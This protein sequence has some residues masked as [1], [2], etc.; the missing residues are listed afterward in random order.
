[1]KTVAL[2][3]KKTLEALL[4]LDWASKPWVFVLILVYSLSRVWQLN[5]GFGLYGDAWRI[6]NTAFDISY[7][8]IYNPSRFP[9]YPLPEFIDS[10]FIRWGWVA[11]NGLAAVLNLVAVFAFASI[12]KDLGVRNK[13]L[14]VLAYAFIPII[15]VHSGGTIDYTWALSFVIFT[16]FF[17]LRDRWAIAGLMMG[18]AIGSRV[19]AGVFILPLLYL[20]YQRKAGLKNTIWLCGVA[21]V[22]ALVLF[23]PLFIQY[24]L[25]F[26]TYYSDTISL[27]AMLYRVVNAFG[28]LPILFGIIV[29]IFSLKSLVQSLLKRDGLVIFLFATVLLYVALYIK[30]PYKAEY[31]LP[32]VPFGLLLLNNISRR[33][34]FIPL[35]FLLVLESFVSFAIHTTQP[36]VSVNQGRIAADIENRTVIMAGA[37]ELLAQRDSHT[38]YVVGGYWV[39]AR[40]FSH[41]EDIV[42]ED[43]GLIGATARLNTP[44]PTPIFTT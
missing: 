22:T 34:L 40:Y 21:G 33:M 42:I 17:A 8:H 36:L 39:L 32:A 44:I 5:A 26:F 24:G 19:T 6:A 28:I 3:I 9:G 35:V 23:L 14:L 10:L 2:R 37:R 29:V 13:G 15:W 1:M 18:L 12:L 43:V 25:S 31:M 7:L 30:V 11:T 27:E 20:A 41:S 4:E 38:A 16:W